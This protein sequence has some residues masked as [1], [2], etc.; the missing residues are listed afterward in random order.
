MSWIDIVIVALVVLAVWRGKSQGLVR[1]LAGWA[2]V[3]AGFVL[4][5][6]IASTLSNKIT[7]AAWR[8]LLAFALLL[9]FC[10]GGSLAGKIV[11]SALHRSLKALKLGLLDSAGGIVFA[12][13]GSLITCWLAGKVLSTVSWGSLA[14]AVHHSALLK[15]LNKAM[16]SVPSFATK[17]QTLLT[18]TKLP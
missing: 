18:N 15:Q 7:H 4:G 1:Q 8:P 6:M 5:T 9:A 11:G 17:A 14:T 3:I 13:A 16:P 10:I 2:G 12:V